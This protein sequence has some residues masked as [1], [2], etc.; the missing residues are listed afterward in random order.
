MLSADGI[1]NP[2]CLVLLP[3]CLIPVFRMELLP[4]PRLSFFSVILTLDF[5]SNL[6]DCLSR[7]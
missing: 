2:T 6:I 7:V 4:F 1:S 5:D 3:V